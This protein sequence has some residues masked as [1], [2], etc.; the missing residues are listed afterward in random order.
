MSLSPNATPGDG[1]DLYLGNVGIDLSIGAGGNASFRITEH[2]LGYI[3]VPED[4]PYGDYYAVFQ[5]VPSNGEWSELDPADNWFVSPTANVRVGPPPEADLSLSDIDWSPER[6]VDL[7]WLEHPTQIY[8]SL[9]SDPVSGLVYGDAAR[10]HV[11]LSPDAEH[12][13]GND[14]HLGHIGVEL[15]VEP[16]TD[17]P[18]YFTPTGLGYVA[19]PEGT[20]NGD[21]YAV[22][23]T[24]L[25]LP[26]N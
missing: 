22:S 9:H 24:H 23:Y 7:D 8:F 12:S 11:Y 18:F 15:T 13:D 20:S 14:V 21:Y 17:Q 25:T 10:V 6:P 2:G 19:V 16:G 5:I 26:T 1:D 4:A 3:T